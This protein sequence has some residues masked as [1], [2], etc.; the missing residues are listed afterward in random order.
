MDQL[1]PEIITEIAQ[2]LDVADRANFR[3]VFSGCSVVQPPTLMPSDV[4]LGYHVLCNKEAFFKKYMSSF[5]NHVRPNRYFNTEIVV[6]DIHNTIKFGKWSY[7]LARRYNQ[8]LSD[9][10]RIDALERFGNK[11]KCIRITTNDHSF[12]IGIP[13]EF[14]Y[15]DKFFL[16]KTKHNAYGVTIYATHVN[17][18]SLKSESYDTSLVDFHKIQHKYSLL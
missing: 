17:V 9:W 3:L 6:H 2:W 10:D 7:Y 14:D 8:M 18:R 16:V 15:D 1:P 5:S 4:W 12:L 11:I 13:R